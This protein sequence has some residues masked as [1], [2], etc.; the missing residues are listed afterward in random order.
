MKTLF[1]K[2]IKA[3]VTLDEKDNFLK[4]TNLL[5]RLK[6]SNDAPTG[7][8]ILKIA[9]K[10]SARV[11]GRNDIGELSV[12][13]AADLFMINSNRL[14]FVG[15]IEDPKCTLGTVGL[16]DPV[17]YTIINGKIVVKDGKL[18]TIDEEKIVYEGQKSVER[19]FAK[20]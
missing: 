7:Y 5:H 8:D 12:R 4:N 14:E 1:I 20:I 2:N 19:L 6:Y 17:D 16:K 9:T 11:L 15:V 10:G 13:K 3:L 18:T